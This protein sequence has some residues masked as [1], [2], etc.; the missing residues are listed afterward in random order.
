MS[1]TEYVI[2]LRTKTPLYIGLTSDVVADIESARRFEFITVAIGVATLDHR[3]A[4]DQFTV[5]AV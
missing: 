3:L 5:E 2:K 1:R 4:D